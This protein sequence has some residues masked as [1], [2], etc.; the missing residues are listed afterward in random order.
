MKKIL[1][2][3]AI[4]ILAASSC[5]AAATTSAATSALNLTDGT[6]LVLHGHATAALATTARIGKCSTGVSVA[7][8]A[9]T[10]GYSMMTQ[11]KSGTKAYGS[12][13]DSTAI[14]Q[15]ITDV[16]PGNV[17]ATL[18]ASDTT[19]FIVDTVWKAM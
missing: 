1:T 6:G 16:E 11:H 10:T 2:L 19:D 15:T 5:F 13:Y 9:S 3:T 18:S 14:Y 4:L 8:Q 17:A 7:W 12:S